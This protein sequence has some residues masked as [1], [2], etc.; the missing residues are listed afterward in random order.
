MANGNDNERTGGTAARWTILKALGVG[1]GAALLVA[2]FT[3][4]I[5]PGSFQ[6]IE[7]SLFDSRV[8]LAAAQTDPYEGEETGIVLIRIDDR[9]LEEMGRFEQWPRSVH[10]YL[11]DYLAEAGA[12]AIFFDI[13]FFQ[14]DID[15]AMDLEVAR[16]FGQ[17]GVVYTALSLI[18][19]SSYVF[20]STV[21]EDVFIRNAPRSIVPVENIAGAEALPDMSGLRRQIL[22]GPGE[23]LIRSS[24]GLG[25]VNAFPD[26]DGI[27]RR[28]PLLWRNH[29][30]VLPTASFHLFLDLMGINVDEVRFEP[31]VALHVGD[32]AIPV[33]NLG[34]FL[35]HWYPNDYPPYREISYSDVF[36]QR[37]PAEYFQGKICIVGPTAAALG[38]IKPT[39]V[40]PALAGVKIHTTL[41]ANLF[42]GDQ[43]GRM[44]EWLGILLTVLLGALVAFFAF[45]FRISLG[46]ILTA[47]LFV[48]FF[49]AAFYIY[50]RV[51]YWSELFRPAFGLVVGYTSAMVYR[52]MTEE[53]QKRVIKG[54]FQQYVSPAVVDE[55]LDDPDKLRLGGERR[56]LTILFADIQGFTSFSEKLDPEELTAFLNKFLTSMT[57]RIFEYQ[58]TVDKY[59][60]DAVMAIFGA[61]LAFDDHA[62]RGV[63]AALGMREELERVREEWGDFLPGTFDLKLGLNTGPVVVGNMGS[64]MRFDYTVLGDNVNLAARLEAL[65]RQYGVSLLI[66]EATLD[67]VGDAFLVR[68]LDSVRVKGKEKPVVIYEVLGRTGSDHDTPEAHRLADA[69]ADGLQYYRAQAWDQALEIFA[70]LTDDPAAAVFSDRCRTLKEQ[71][72]GEEWDGVWTMTTK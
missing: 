59:I 54:A 4:I 29:G 1:G 3:Y 32:Y 69:F 36:A 71:P 38:D 21:D 9:S 16:G 22:E 58:G 18:D 26:E 33:D 66:S 70:R 27:V 50:L 56:E 67:A 5:A 23:R 24:L 19:S 43:V 44:P 62:E 64:D 48:L 37:L 42:M 61:P 15:P 20:M 17:A 39:P 65:T 55:M 14:E 34:R 72:P 40:D 46:A 41:L 31:G 8:W 51:S 57:R 49:I 25:L 30:Y 35:L 13:V 10:S 47:V 63:G 53:K 45:R 68:E 28:Q 6:K 52:Y 11:A 2:L 7:Y 12:A 60:G